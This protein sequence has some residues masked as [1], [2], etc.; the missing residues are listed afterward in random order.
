M[1]EDSWTGVRKIELNIER[2]NK[3]EGEYTICLGETERESHIIFQSITT[4]KDR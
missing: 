1:S 2:D 3:K 4:H